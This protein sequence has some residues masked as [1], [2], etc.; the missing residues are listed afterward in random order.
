MFYSNFC[1]GGNECLLIL[2]DAKI[3]HNFD[4]QQITLNKQ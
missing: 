2:K 1:S 4:L 3:N